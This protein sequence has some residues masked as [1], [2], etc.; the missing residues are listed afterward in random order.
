MKAYL[1][2]L[3]AV[4]AATLDFRPALNAAETPRVIVTTDGE[5]DDQCSM[6]RFLLYAN[7]WD[8]EGIILSSS[9][10]HWKGRRSWSGDDWVEPFLDAYEKVHPNLIKHDPN[11]PA[12]DFLRAR[13]LLGNVKAEGEME[14]VTPGS[15]RIVEVLK[16]Q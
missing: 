9:Q 6:V 15:Q 10:Y 8:I 16:P 13:T 12:P 11:Y 3:M 5:I 1:I 14:E 2:F 4:A 7:E